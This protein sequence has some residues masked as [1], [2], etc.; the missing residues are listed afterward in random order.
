[1]L[2]EKGGQDGIRITKIKRLYSRHL[3][4]DNLLLHDGRILEGRL[5]IRQ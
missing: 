4:G 2:K 5:R 3:R 1:M